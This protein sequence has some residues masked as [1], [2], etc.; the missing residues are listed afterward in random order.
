MED[1]YMATTAV[2]FRMDSDLKNDFAQICD[3]I[4]MSVSTAFTVFAKKVVREHAIP[5]ELEADPFYSAGNMHALRASIARLDA[6]EGIEKT[7][8]ELEAM[9]H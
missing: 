6:G 7:I 5:F 9:E 2:N 1:D 4:G 8:E 3:D